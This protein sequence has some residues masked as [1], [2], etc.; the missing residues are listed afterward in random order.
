MEEK[1][2]SLFD[3]RRRDLKDTINFTEPENIPVGLEFISWPVGYAGYKT[4]Q[5]IENEELRIKAFKKLFDDVYFDASKGAPGLPIPI[6]FIEAVGSTAFKISNDE[7]T[8]QHMQNCA[9]GSDEYD[10]LIADPRDFIINVL[11]KRK[12]KNLNGSRQEVYGAMKDAAIKLRDDMMGNVKVKKMMNEE[13]GILQLMGNTGQLAPI[14]TLFDFIRGF[15]ETLGDIRRQP[16]KVKATSDLLLEYYKNPELD[17]EIKNNDYLIFPGSSIHTAAFLS[18]K[19]LREFWW[20]GMKKSIQRN[21]DAGGKFWVK[22]EGDMK[23]VFDF[24]KEFPKGTF[25]IQLGE[26]DDAYE[27]Y[28]RIGDWAVVC[29][30]IPL[31]K[32]K[33]STKN[34]C[35]DE[36]KKMIDTFAPGGGYIW[37]NSTPLLSLND[38]NTENLISVYDFVHEY[39]RK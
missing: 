26:Q 9:M 25:L 33:Y 3:K 35:I 14:D 29:A 36:S 11:A 16:E 13:Y 7:I 38:V 20:P 27:A 6:K 18:E 4:R 12:C 22:G 2:K 30:A 21:I 5:V 37:M 15:R 34:E 32:L 10:R 28:K 24:F 8:V 23:Y 19:Q 1:I 17:K 31:S 39:G